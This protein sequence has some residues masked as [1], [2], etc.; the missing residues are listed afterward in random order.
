MHEPAITTISGHND[1]RV[2]S[3]QSSNHSS[4]RGLDTYSMHRSYP[5]VEQVGETLFRG[6]VVRACTPW[7]DEENDDKPD[8]E[9]DEKPNEEP[10]E[11]PKKLEEKQ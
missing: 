10:D 8:E 1:T 5:R 7:L 2:G 4:H 6:G 9:L 3:S 11:E